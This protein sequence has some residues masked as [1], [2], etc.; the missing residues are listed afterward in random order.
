MFILSD[1]CFRSHSIGTGIDKLSIPLCWTCVPG[2]FASIICTL[3]ALVSLVSPACAEWEHSQG[4]GE[5]FHPITEANSFFAC[6]DQAGGTIVA[7]IDDGASI[8]NIYLSRIDQTGNELWGPEG[9]ILPVDIGSL[10]Q[11]GPLDLAPDGEGGVYCAFREIIGGVHFLRIWHVLADG[12][13]D[14]GYTIAAFDPIQTVLWLALETIQTTGTDDVIVIWT[15]GNGYPDVELYAAR[16]DETGSVLWLTCFWEDSNTDPDYI[17]GVTDSDGVDGVVIGLNY[18]PYLGVPEHRVQRI[19]TDGVAQWGPRG[20][21]VWYNH[22]TI[23][24]ILPDGLGGAFACNGVGY[25]E[26]A[27]QH[28]NSSGIETWAAGGLTILN[29]DTQGEHSYPAFCVDGSGGLYAVDGVQDLN[30]QHVDLAGNLLWGPN[31]ITITARSGW[32]E[33]ADIAT[34]GFGGALVVYLDHYSAIVSDPWAR[35]LS[36]TRLDVWG[37]KVWEELDAWWSYWDYDPTRTPE[38]AHVNPDGSGGGHMVWLEGHDNIND[39]E[40]YAKGFGPDGTSPPVPGLTHMLP[41]AGEP[42]SYGPV[43]IAGNYLEASQSFKLQRQGPPDTPITGTVFL[44]HQLIGGDLDLTHLGSGAYD[45]VVSV[46][47]TPVDTLV[48]AYGVGDRPDC[49]MD[50][51]FEPVMAEPV[52]PAADQRRV[53]FD[54][55]GN[56]HA[57]WVE[58]E[59]TSAMY[60]LQYAQRDSLGWSS[61]PVSL[62]SAA[63]PLWDPCLVAGPDSMLHMALV[64]DLGSV[65]PLL[66]LKYKPDGSYI[67]SDELDLGLENRRP[68]IA[69]EYT[70]LL[71]LVY[72]VVSGS[73]TELYHTTHDGYGFDSPYDLGA[74][75]NSREPDLTQ[76][77]SDLMLIFLRD[78]WMPGITDVCYQRHITGAWQTPVTMYAGLRCFSPSLAWDGAEKLLFAWVLDNTGFHPLVHTALFEHDVR[79]P[80]RWRLNSPQVYSC[81]VSAGIDRFYLLTQESESGRPMEFHVRGGDGNVFYPKRQLNG[82]A[83]VDY[84]SFAA[85]PGGTRLVAIWVDYEVVGEPMRTWYCPGNGMVGVAELPARSATM[86]VYPNPFN[87]ETQITFTV[88]EAGLVDLAIYD[89]RGQLVRTLLHGR[90]AAGPQELSWDGRD[91]G[92]ANLASGMYFARLSLPGRSD[93]LAIKLTLLK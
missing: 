63:V 59:H 35:A 87:P 10:G 29:V 64:Y 74:G 26:V 92:G 49:D 58:Y 46:A 76:F 40:V 53:V 73:T 8:Q 1:T 69:V 21:A 62:V 31:G 78:S 13:A 77:G 36:A 6:P 15:Q 34:D 44:S 52:L 16:M 2:V 11:G 43:L 41:D 89:L 84:A 17:W 65:K 88:P 80:V 54:L 7:M 83:D 56:A 9:I 38:I 32:Q 23:V 91:D 68:T 24:D 85:E 37:N 28:V 45:L 67:Y 12:V 22:G 71:H 75:S 50:E 82:H 57:I 20:Y 5:I 81:S 4:W 60:L 55:A 3:L 25:G 66:Y 19:T 18:L 30:A 39:N 42:G 48:D 72:E 70:G 90:C 79:G 47:G 61:T 93:G 86:R 27:V 33:R 14:Q 51:N